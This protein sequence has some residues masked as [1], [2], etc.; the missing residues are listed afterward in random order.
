MLFY[1]RRFYFY[2][3]NLILIT[4]KEVYF[5]RISFYNNKRMLDVFETDYDIPRILMACNIESGI[6]ITPGD[7][8]IIFDE[9][10]NVPKA[11]ESLKYFSEEAP[12]YHVIAPVRCWEQPF[13]K[14]FLIRWERLNC[15]IY[16]P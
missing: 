1:G 15:L 16:I 5:I 7:T 3:I 12:E 11:L 4:Y 8:L 6:T 2:R 10:Q 14:E 9:I 13:M